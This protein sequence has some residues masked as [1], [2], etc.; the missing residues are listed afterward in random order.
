VGALEEQFY[1]ALLDGLGLTDDP[2]LPDRMD[3]RQWP[4]LRERF[5]HVF[6]S[7]TR[8]EWWQVFEGT[9][10][11]VAPVWSLLE[12]TTDRHNR[13]RGVFV[14][15][16]GTVQ[17]DVAPRFSVTPGSVGRV[18]AVGQHSDEIRAELGL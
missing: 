4:A 7:R 16:E 2:S 1:A 17:P 8:S 11:C 5:T 18:P 12:A 10:A 3:P 6:A 13:E 15:V 9:D 14:E